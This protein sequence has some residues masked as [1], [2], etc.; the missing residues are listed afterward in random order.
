MEWN[1]LCCLYKDED[2]N[3]QKVSKNFQ[4]LIEDMECIVLLILWVIHKYKR[5]FDQVRRIF[6]REWLWDFPMISVKLK[7]IDFENQV[8][9]KPMQ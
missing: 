4:N 8:T 7:L 9:M 1:A 6:L 3:F 2:N 5:H